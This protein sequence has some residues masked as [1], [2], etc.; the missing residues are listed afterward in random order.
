M[1]KHILVDIETYGP[2]PSIFPMVSFA[3]ICYETGNEFY[4]EINPEDTYQ[5]DEGAKKVADLGLCWSAETRY[6]SEKA[7]KSFEKWLI[8]QMDE[9]DERLIMVSDSTS[10]DHSFMTFYSYKYLGH[11]LF[12]HSS[13]SLNQIFKGLKGTM[14]A[15]IGSLRPKGSHT[16]NAL[17]DIRGNAVALEKMIEKHGLKNFGK[18]QEGKKW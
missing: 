14:K 13:V 16:H 4:M 12:G 8:H 17:D 10:F 11:S 9:V 15:N 3:A 6:T 2:V 7:M 18:K 5:V 1:V